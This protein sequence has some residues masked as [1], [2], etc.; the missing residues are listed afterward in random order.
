[1]SNKEAAT[2][3]AVAEYF[4]DHSSDWEAH[5]DN[6]GCTCYQFRTR[7]SIAS[8]VLRAIARKRGGPGLLLDLGCGGGLQAGMAS[9]DG[10]SVI[11]VDLSAEMLK[12]AAQNCPAG[13]WVVASADALPFRAGSFDAVL[14]LGVIGYVP[15]PANALRQVRQCLKAGGHLVLSSWV[16]QHLLLDRLSTAV[17]Y[18]PDRLYLRAKELITRRPRRPP[19][20]W[21]QT[22]ITEHYR[23]LGIPEWARMLREAG[24]APKR[25]WAI[26]FGRLRFMSRR[27]WPKAFDV[28]LSRFFEA[29]SSLP[30]MRALRRTALAV[31]FLAAVP[32]S[33]QP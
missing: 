33:S 5:Y 30:G 21:A 27:F 15:E 22:F 16:N 19:A 4:S 32:P 2:R 20:P 12:R 13:S 29:V 17:S 6:G 10:W 1:M 7:A 28:A 18:L 25:E 14:M 9:R 31:L 24:L 3:K 23:I 26:D 11:G 8:R